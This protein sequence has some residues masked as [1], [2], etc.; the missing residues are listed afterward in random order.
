MGPAPSMPPQR[1][2]AARAAPRP[3]VLALLLLG[4]V[5]AHVA[6]LQPA[7]LR[8][9]PV[10]AP[11]PWQVRLVEAPPERRPVPIPPVLAAAERTTPQVAPLVARSPPT[12]HG[13]RDTA[14][15]PR[16][17]TTGARAGGVA[18]APAPAS[19]PAAAPPAGTPADA[20]QP[21]PAAD[22]PA[23]QL[24]PA[25]TWRYVVTQRWRGQQLAGSATMD[26][27]PAGTGY[28]LTLAWSVPPLPPRTLTSTGTL[29]PE[30][31]QPRRFGLRARGEFATHL[32]AAG[33]RV[34]FSSNRPDAVLPPGLQDRASVLLQLA[35]WL[36][37]DPARWTPGATLQVAVAGSHEVT[38]GSFVVEGLETLDLPGGRTQALRLVRPPV[39]A[40]D[41][42]WEAWF[43]PGAAYGPVRLRLTSP[44]GDATD[45]QWSGTDNR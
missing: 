21:A 42:R 7:A 44:A 36:A 45:L 13:H 10:P 28:G 6:V 11:P 20:P 24:P 1:P 26:W 9:R 37:A 8:A 15:T 31:L 3:P 5:A 12:A 34:V 41:L 39:H 4:V 43:A 30:G 35:G 25:A 23:P 2:R 32:D 18:D 38:A 14:R 29:G 22:L 19:A 16:A 40:W 17:V 33:G 27:Q